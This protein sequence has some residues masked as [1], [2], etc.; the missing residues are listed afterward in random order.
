MTAYKTAMLRPAL[1]LF[2]LLSVIT[3]LLYPLAITGVAQLLFPA[4]ANGSLVERDGRVVGS[5]LIGQAFVSPR[6]FW[7]R[8]SATGPTPYNAGA[9]SGSNQAPTNP[10]LV[11]A[12]KQRAEA[13]RAADPGNTAPVPVDLV[14]ASAS[15]LDPEISLAAA[16]WQIV[17]VARERGLPAERVRA[18]VE[19]ATVRPLAGMFGEARV[20]VLAL[21]MALDQITQ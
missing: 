12:V 21:N 10:A 18:L 11:D 8:P 15:G 19:A 16:N 3:G 17:R 7:S 2:L 9:S 1:V 6:Y 14:T 13:L 5:A 4:Q 20:N